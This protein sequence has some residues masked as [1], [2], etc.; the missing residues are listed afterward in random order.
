MKRIIAAGSGTVLGALLI[1]YP[2]AIAL[3]Y[4]T[5]FVGAAAIVA[6]LVRRVSRTFPPLSAFV[7][8]FTWIELGIAVVVVGIL[9]AVAIPKFNNTSRRAGLTVEASAYHLTLRPTGRHS[10]EVE[11]QLTLGKTAREIFRS[12]TL[13]LQRRSLNSVIESL[14]L[15]RLDVTLSCGQTLPINV[16]DGRFADAGKDY[17]YFQITCPDSATLQ[18]GPFPR[19]MFFEAAI[20]DSV[21]RRAFTDTETLVWRVDA[22]LATVS[23]AYIRSPAHWLRPFVP[24][25]VWVHSLPRTILLVI[26]LA[27]TLFL[28]PVLVERSISRLAARRGAEPTRSST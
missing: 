11:E 15:R 13:V 1:S 17:R 7:P 19:D 10:F 26:G 27:L 23:F 28:V 8:G 12:D 16:I 21:S 18:L 4:L 2:V 25:A 9:A 14:L 22:S 6:A 20:T 24:E 3:L 5:L